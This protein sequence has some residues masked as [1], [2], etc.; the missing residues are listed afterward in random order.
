MAMKAR[1]QKVF[2]TVLLVCLMAWAS[3][4]LGG[5][6]PRFQSRREAED[7]V[8]VLDGRV[9]ELQHDRYKAR[10]DGDR[11][12]QARAEADLKSVQT[13]RADILRQLGALR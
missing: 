8:R 12:G 13:E 11:E 5:E 9:V 3:G 4:A 2:G 1:M 10:H 7:R 6:A